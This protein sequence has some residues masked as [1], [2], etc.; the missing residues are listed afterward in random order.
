MF[1]PYINAPYKIHY[2]KNP[3]EILRNIDGETS[4]AVTIL[5]QIITLFREFIILSAIFI[6]LVLVDTLISFSVFLIFTLLVGIFFFSTKRIITNNGKILQKFRGFKIK[7]IN[8]VLGAIK[9]VKIFHKEKIL[10]RKFSDK[11]SI[12]EKSFLIKYFLI[13]LPRLVLETTVIISVVFI[14]LI[15][16]FIERDLNTIIPLLSL[17]TVSAIRMLPSF[18]S[19][20]TALAYIKSLTPSL[21]LIVDEIRLLEGLKIV[22]K[23][24]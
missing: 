20:T 17:F 14:L 10:E 4:G 13:S 2:E 7:D 15:F 16:I 5:L 9:E 24:F 12:W 11:I 6:L 1:K 18:N 8:E 3:A 19:I 21:N 22:K 23:R